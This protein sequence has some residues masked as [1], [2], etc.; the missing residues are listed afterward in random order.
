MEDDVFFSLKNE[1]THINFSISNY[2]MHCENDFE[3]HVQYQR[4]TNQ[5]ECYYNYTDIKHGWGSVEDTITTSE[6]YNFSNLF[7][8]FIQEKTSSFVF[9]TKHKLFKFSI[10]KINSNH[11]VEFKIIDGL[12]NIWIC[13][14]NEHLTKSEVE[15]LANIIFGW[16]KKFP[17]IDEANAEVA[18]VKF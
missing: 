1:T 12:E 11:F 17:V 6:L 18:S 8:N 4:K 16:A 7:L 10:K 9:E 2:T 3:K 5:L 13:A 15:A 14:T